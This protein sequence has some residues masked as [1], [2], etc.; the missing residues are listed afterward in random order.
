MGILWIRWLQNCSASINPGLPTTNDVMDCSLLSTP[1]FKVTR[2]IV[3]YNFQDYFKRVFSIFNHWQWLW[4]LT[5]II[6]HLLL[7]RSFLA[8]EQ[9]HAFRYL[10]R[11]S[12]LLPKNCEMYTNIY[13]GWIIQVNRGLWKVKRM[14][15]DLFLSI[16]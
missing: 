9:I 11:S 15:N 5:C 7:L 4:A 8:D 14:V 13:R 6:D 12:L 3:V 16:L 1:D 2:L 10:I